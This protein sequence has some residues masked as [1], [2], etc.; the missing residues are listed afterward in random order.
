MQ[1]DCPSPAGLAPTNRKL[2]FTDHNDGLVLG[3]GFGKRKKSIAVRLRI[4]AEGQV[5]GWA[6]VLLSWVV[7]FKW[8]DAGNL[9]ISRRGCG[10]HTPPKRGPWGDG[11][12]R[13][14]HKLAGWSCQLSACVVASPCKRRNPAP[15]AKV[16][17][18]V[19]I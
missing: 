1:P 12:C 5:M 9:E 6:A 8:R 4:F 11:C 17:D 13:V 14:S 19:H 16:F 2:Q 3:I 7:V 18:W 10:A 15:S